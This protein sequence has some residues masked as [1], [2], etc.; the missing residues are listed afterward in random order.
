MPK[1]EAGTQAPTFTL[2]DQDRRPVSLDDF[3]GR[4]VLVYFYPKD[5][6]PGC[7]REACQFNDNLHA[8]QRANVPVL[9]ISSDDATSHQRF[10]AKYGLAFPLLSDPD[11]RMMDA[12]GAWGEKTLYG[13][14]T[15][16]VIRSTFLIDQDGKIARAWYN[17]KA[18]GH[19]AQVLAEVGG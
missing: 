17:V 12:Y 11:H 19:A 9:G 10:R 1:L 16:G 2:P 15:V 5:D 7:T 8:F 14:T 13:K 18:D 4:R 3:K 6:T